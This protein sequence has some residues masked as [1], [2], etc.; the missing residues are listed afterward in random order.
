MCRLCSSRLSS[1]RTRGF[2]EWDAQGDARVVVSF[3]VL[4]E[5]FMNG[6][7]VKTCVIIPTRHN[8]HPM[9]RSHVIDTRVQ[10][11]FV[12]VAKC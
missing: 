11:S 3:C 9:A 6:I 5:I 10:K 8:K 4:E 7:V 1:L 12:F 2:S